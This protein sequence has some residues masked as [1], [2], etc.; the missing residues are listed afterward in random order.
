M[1]RL[2]AIV[3]FAIATLAAFAHAQDLETCLESA[4]LITSFPGTN[5]SFPDDIRSWQRRITPT[6]AGVAWPRT[7]D[8]VAAALAC[9]REAKVLVAARDG[10]H[11]YGSYSLPNAGLTINMTNFQEVSYDESTGLLTYGGGALVSP[12]VSWLW[13]TH[14]ARFPH[15]RAN[16]VGLVGSSIGGGFGSLSRML[17]TP[18]DYLEG[19][20]YMLYNG[21]VV[22]TSRTENPD[23]FWALQGAGSSYGIIL[24]LTTKTWKPTYQQ[25]INYTI[26]LTDSSPGAGVDALLAIQDHYLAGRWPDELTMRWSL[27][28]PPYTGSGFYWGNPDDF[29]TLLK[30]LVDKLPSGT[31]LTRTV[32]DFWAVENVATPSIDVPVDAYPPRSFYL[33][34]L[35]LREDQPFTKTLAT[36][37][38]EFTTLAFNRTDL[39]KFGFI[40]L[41]GGKPAK[42]LSD[43]DTAFAHANSLWLIRW[44][45]RLAAGL[46]KFP[47]DGLS[48]LQNGLE[49]FREQLAAEGVPLRGFVNYRDTALTVDQWSERLY[50]KNYAKLQRLKTV[51]DPE[52]MFTAHPQSIPLPGQQPPPAVN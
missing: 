13:K 18:M 35:V 25:A 24:N 3:A 33:Q 47:A 32:Q 28:A 22:K 49:P 40:D 38:Y 20:T 29:D 30:P 9:A 12:V 52:G 37:L 6:P 5:A 16:M 23:L 10:G 50:G 2:S 15:V 19:A 34:A 42:S 11:C 44:E 43:G 21:T 41:W 36:A 45:G 26:T 31:Q 14:G 39:T 8:E 7:A 27:T 48:Y 46:T 17:G 4:G 51:Y 1:G